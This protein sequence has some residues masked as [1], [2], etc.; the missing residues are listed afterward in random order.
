MIYLLDS[1]VWIAILRGKLPVVTARYVAT[2]RADV[3]ICSVV[4]ADYA[5]AVRRARSRRP[6]GS[7]WTL[8]W[9]LWPASLT[10]MSRPI[11]L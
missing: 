5:T 7:Y 1:N 6:T 10:T 8:C 2:D 9:H 11:T 4:V 3:R